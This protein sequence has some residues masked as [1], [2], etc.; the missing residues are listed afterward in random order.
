MGYYQA[1]PKDLKSDQFGPWS[2][3]PSVHR[4]I[5]QFF[6]FLFF[7]SSFTPSSPFSLIFISRLCLTLTQLSSSRWGLCSASESLKILFPSHGHD[8]LDCFWVFFSSL[9][10]GLA[11]SAS[12]ASSI[13]RYWTY[14]PFSFAFDF[15]VLDSAFL[16]SGFFS[17]FLWSVLCAFV[18]C[19]WLILLE[20]NSFNM[21]VF[22]L[23]KLAYLN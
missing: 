12:V 5:K 18:L 10:L 19:F 22:V 23:V 9:C 2:L 8:L 4:F 15:W 14:L 21:I 3:T 16:K 11:L 17:F 6:F 7:I 20:I 13:I 1:H